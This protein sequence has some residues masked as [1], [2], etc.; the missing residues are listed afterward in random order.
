MMLLRFACL[1]LLVVATHQAS[2]VSS[3]SKLVMRKKLGL[4]PDF[5]AEKI[6]QVAEKLA[7]KR[8][9]VPVMAAT[10]DLAIDGPC[11]SEAV[12]LCGDVE[13]G[14]AR[15]A[16]CLRSKKI[17]AK[18]RGSASPLSD[19]CN[20]KVTSFFEAA[21][22]TPFTFNPELASACA[23]NLEEFC[24]D[25]PDP[26]KMFCLRQNKVQLED[27]CKDEVFKKQL[28]QAEDI[29]MD[30]VLSAACESDMNSL[31]SNSVPQGGGRIKACLRSKKESLSDQCSTFLFKVKMEQAEDIRLD[32]PLKKLCERE[33]ERFC[34]DVE[35][36]KGRV[37]NCLW[38]KKDEPEFGQE[39][40]AK[41]IPAM[42][43]QESDWRL[44]FRLRKECVEEIDS[45]C[46]AA[47]RAAEVKKESGPVIDC[48]KKRMKSI[49]NPKC[50]S[51]VFRAARV[52]A[53]DL[54]ADKV[55][56]NAC[57]GDVER[58]CSGVKSTKL[59]GCL[60]DHLD[61]VSLGCRNAEFEELKVESQ[62]IE[63]KPEMKK[64][65]KREMKTLCKDAPRENAKVI[66]C[67]QDHKDDDD[68]T[69]GCANEIENDEELTA[70]DWRLKWGISNTCQADVSTY[71]S[72]ETEL[73]SPKGAVLA[74]L[75]RERKK[76]S[77]ESGCK[78]EVSRLI[79][80]QAD[81]WK[82][83]AE[84]KAMCSD[85]VA[86]H[87]SSIEPGHG[88]VHE[89]LTEKIDM[90]TPE[91]R[92]EEFKEQEKET[93]VITINPM[94][95]S[96]CAVTIKGVCSDVKD[97]TDGSLMRCLED[98]KDDDGVSSLCK[99]AVTGKTKL[100]NSD[101]RLNPM[102]KL[103]C[104]ADIDHLCA[105]QKEDAQFY[106]MTG[107][108][109]GCLIVNRDEIKSEKCKR[110][111][112]RKQKQR[113]SDIA[114][115]AS[116]SDKCFTDIAKF[117]E[118]AKRTGAGKG[119]VHQCL[120]EHIDELTPECKDYEFKMQVMKG[121]NIKFNPM[122]MSACKTATAKYCKDSVGPSVFPCLR[123][124]QD[125]D[126]F[127]SRC[128]S[129]LV[130]KGVRASSNI[131][132]TPTLRKACKA[133]LDELKSSGKCA[134]DRVSLRGGQDILCLMK[135]Q[136]TLLSEECSKQVVDKQKMQS[137]DMRLRPG[138]KGKDNLP[139]ECT[140]EAKTVCPGVSAGGGRLN[141]CMQR[142][143]D[144]LSSDC[145]AVVESIKSGEDKHFGV[146][147]L[148]AKAC[149]NEKATFCK[150]IPSG[151]QRVWAC[152]RQHQESDGFSDACKQEVALV[153][154]GAAIA[155][156]KASVSGTPLAGLNKADT[157]MIANQ[158]AGQLG[159]EAHHDVSSI[160]ISGWLALAGI[161]SLTSLVGYG[162]YTWWKKSQL[163]SK[164]Y[165]VVV[166]KG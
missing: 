59:H 121:E 67:L 122:L 66:E 24:S 15:L 137:S 55:V 100:K 83:N 101:F 91:C 42:E 102:L 162:L 119:Q 47:V 71:C 116:G 145:A 28:Q 58:F 1:A 148:A 9:D 36:G 136:D 127:P 138:M 2:P 13:I 140:A 133:D 124:H 32:V 8:L 130:N 81:N 78:D 72:D 109:L 62:S 105:A 89:C 48:L 5:A 54:N 46:E 99:A 10:E 84:L 75:V 150:A 74:C 129:E 3:L 16:K 154:F 149:S 20:R 120:F 53:M 30:P 6:K 134:K 49:T 165:T 95:K 31:C 152:L 156:L 135:N 45:A 93:E 38:D 80:I 107:K 44:D 70:T 50:K 96:S 151:S 51:E 11:K 160:Q 106:E 118:D 56:K 155:N 37:K 82:N 22:R 163:N 132:F 87:C 113:A 92:S 14:S 166:N 108:V 52:Q 147:P 88:R 103:E 63:L 158:L 34:G 94:V 12:D 142:N 29:R 114:M 115:D 35:M 128:R 39:C 141:R 25:A 57:D 146:N 17:S 60:R 112:E 144:K 65:C 27:K 77:K 61:Q 76:L 23:A 64:Q 98:H 19:G 33:A 79:R 18:V 110:S 161:F 117:C 41:L 21:A 143:K 40:L 164:S 159:G 69:K 97:T 68:M 111:V 157:K 4:S 125:E 123:E 43:A 153:K 90:L 26:M 126:D 131:A 139:A 73:E 85:D 7:L 86:I 104:K